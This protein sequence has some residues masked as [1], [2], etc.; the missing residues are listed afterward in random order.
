MLHLPPPPTVTPRPAGRRAASRRR[1]LAVGRIG[2]LAASLALL[3][4]AACLS[5]GDH[6]EKADEAA[7]ELIGATQE[8]ALGRREAF[9][10]ERPAETLRRRL[11]LE[12]DLPRASDASLD[13]RELEPID[14]WPEDAGPPGVDLPPDSLIRP[15]TD[16][17][18]QVSLV[19]ALRIAAANSREFQQQ[20]E[21]VFRA[22]LTLDL[23]CNEFHSQLQGLLEG[24]I[25][26]DLDRDAFGD[27]TRTTGVDGTAS[28]GLDRRFQNGVSISTQIGVDVARLL[29]SPYNRSLAVFSDT[30]ITIP[31][32]RGA[33]RHI[34]AEPLIQAERDLLYAIL[35]FERFK[36]TFVV[37]VASDYLSVLQ[38]QDQVRN[39]EQNYRSLIQ[40]TRQLRRNFEAGRK[41][42]FEVDQAEQDELR[43]R[44]SWVSAVQRYKQQLDGF[45][46]RLG[47]PPDAALAL[48]REELERLGADVR[49]TLAATLAPRDESDASGDGA[50]SDADIV[51]APPG[52]G[53]PGP[54]EVAERAAVE[55]A[56]ARRLDLA[57]SQ[58]E[59]YDAQRSLVVAADGLR[60]EVTLFGSAGLGERRSVGSATAPNSET[61]RTSEASYDA[62]LTI[63]PPLERTAE[64]VQYRSAWIALDQIVR[65]LQEL[66]DQIK[67]DVRSR[68]RDLL[69]AREGLRIQETAARLA[70]SRV[71]NTRLLLDAGRAQTR[72]LLDAQEDLVAAQDDLTNALISYRIAELELQ[73][74]MGILQVTEDGLWTELDP[75]EL[76][77]EHRS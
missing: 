5:P 22:A 1:P 41:P 20:K 32:L 6:R 71:K 46:I 3:S 69:E 35:R 74:D 8:V 54:W 65:D 24:G 21:A 50:S 31:L 75:K 28:L 53:Q 27:R 4:S 55:L 49:A 18:A 15:T 40:T 67:L 76:F 61:L 26:S 42:G 68:L 72:D 45:R 7:A 64:R 39:A 36:R 47:L 25:T 77:D 29:T 56:L 34:V 43:S 11:M 59:V 63:D 37:D 2:G 30:S 52:D 14:H 44:N 33:G 38:Q 9:T 66:E 12:Q 70:E 51:L 62:M 10:I 13:R 19:E 17:S 23:E 48:V 60:G 58:G 57:V 73:R 16:G